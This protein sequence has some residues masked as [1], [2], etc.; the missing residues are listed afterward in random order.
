MCVHLSSCT[1][2]IA[3]FVM[4]ICSQPHK[5]VQLI[6]LYDCRTDGGDCKGDCEG[7]REGVV[8]L[9]W[10]EVIH[11]KGFEWDATH[12]IPFFEFRHFFGWIGGKGWDQWV[13]CAWEMYERGLKSLGYSTHQD[14]ECYGTLNRIIRVVRKD[15][16][17]E[18]VGEMQI[19]EHTPSMNVIF[20]DHFVLV[21]PRST[22]DPFGISLNSLAF[23]GS[24]FAKTEKKLEKIKEIGLHKLLQ[25]ACF[26]PIPK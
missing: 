21:I 4:I 18:V 12:T 10:I 24:F 1:Q 19:R 3:V 25:E 16:P 8:A 20:T 6:P 13:S 23:G 17:T 14:P 2:H 5:H 11:N 22:G 9:P 7:D 26:P 15:D